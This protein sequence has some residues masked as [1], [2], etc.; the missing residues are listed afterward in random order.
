MAKKGELFSTHLVGRKREPLGIDSI[1]D[2]GGDSRAFDVG[3]VPPRAN[4]QSSSRRKNPMTSINSDE[5]YS[6]S[7]SLHRSAVTGKPRVHKQALWTTCL[8]ALKGSCESEVISASRPL[9]WPLRGLFARLQ[10]HG[11]GLCQGSGLW[12]AARFPGAGLHGLP[13]L[14]IPIGFPSKPG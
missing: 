8:D 11:C 4:M 1:Q 10:F 9:P 7:W 5:D 6:G 13:A 12:L 3:C 2:S 14:R